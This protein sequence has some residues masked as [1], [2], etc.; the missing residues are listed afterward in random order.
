MRHALFFAI[1]LVAAG[2]AYGQTCN[3]PYM[4]ISGIN[5]DLTGPC[6]GGFEYST[7]QLGGGSVTVMKSIDK[8]SAG[9]MQACVASQPLT[10]A[11]LNPSSG[12]KI[13]FD[14]VMITSYSQTV[15][16]GSGAETFSF[17]YAKA[18]LPGGMGTGF[19]NQPAGSGTGFDNTTRRYTGRPHPIH[20]SVVVIGADR[21]SQA[22]TNYQLTARPG[23]VTT[24]IQLGRSSP[25]LRID[26]GFIEVQSAS[27]NVLARYQFTGGVLTNGILRPARV[28][29]A[30]TAGALPR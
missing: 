6:A 22:V 21:H 13:E 12:D 20:I 1:L 15:N 17:K 16:N 19:D 23:A 25:S 29:P 14:T 5:G 9:L 7:V 30:P 2:N 26:S 24:S 27:G 11:V 28:N 18:R 8:A 10:K 4:Q 3:D